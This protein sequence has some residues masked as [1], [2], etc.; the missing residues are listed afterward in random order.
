MLWFYHPSGHFWTDSTR[1]PHI[2]LSGN[3]L[4]AR[5]PQWH[6][7]QRRGVGI[8]SDFVPMPWHTCHSYCQSSSDMSWGTS[9]QQPCHSTQTEGI[10][11][12]GK[13]PGRECH[14]KLCCFIHPG[15][16]CSCGRGHSR[17]HS[18]ANNDWNKT[19]DVCLGR[20]SINKHRLG[21]A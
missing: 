3:S 15:L 21:E 13:C 9:S 20:Q 7:H 17:G 6:L 16:T 2:C 10:A 8:F 5:H 19:P 11:M 4:M 12:W 1:T 14:T 18:L